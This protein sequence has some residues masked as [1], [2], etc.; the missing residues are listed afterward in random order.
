MAERVLVSGANGFVGRVVCRRL[1]QGGDAP[2]AGIRHTRQW[3][4][5]QQSVPGLRE[6]AV[7]GDLGN[8]PDLRASLRNVSAV[9][10]AAARLDET[11]DAP[12]NSLQEYRR[13]N[14]E[15]TKTLALAAAEQGVRR[16]VFVSSTKVNGEWTN[17][18]PFTEETPPSPQDMYAISK[19][20]AEES[21]RSIAAKTGIEVAIVRPPLV[22]GPRV[23]ANFLRLMSMVEKGLPLPL[24][25][26]GN[27]RS[28]IS[29]D[30]LADILVCCVNHPG[31]LNQTFMAS[32]GEDVSTRELIK[33]L[34]GFLN[35]TARFLPIP[36]S[37]M[38]LAGKL[39]RREGAV[40][41]LLD[42]L[43]IDSTKARL[44]LDWAPPL[45]LDEGLAGTAR[46][47][48]ESLSRPSRPERI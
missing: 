43:T 19:W 28:M 16:L 42:S 44:K 10:H 30:N 46:W 39:L 40:N 37:I 45:S 17:H 34:A 48:L 26:T 8:N 2:V 13:V 32:D 25:D 9:V 41:R 35:R 3:A 4:A 33:R 20:E 7:L 31:A 11:P 22:Y 21:L 23:G 24:P 12:G 6:S 29:V 1:L 27:R 38:R 36:A 14:V 47:Y 15:G 18:S 5:L